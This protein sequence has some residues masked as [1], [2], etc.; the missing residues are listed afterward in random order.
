[1]A[2]RVPYRIQMFLWLLLHNKLLM[3]AERY[4]RHMVDSPKCVICSADEEDLNHV[5]R[6]CPNATLTWQALQS[7]N[8]FGTDSNESREVWL[9]KNLTQQLGVPN[10]PTKFLIT[11]WYIWKWRCKTCFG[12]QEEIPRE[13]N[14]F[15]TA[16]FR[17]IIRVLSLD[18]SRIEHPQA[19]L[20]GGHIKWELPPEGWVILKKDGAA[21]GN[22]GRAGAGGVIRGDRGNWIVGF[23]EHLGHCSSMKA[24][25]R[26][27]FRG[28]QLAK[29]ENLHK[30]WIRTDSL[31]VVG[32]LTNKM[33]WHP[34]HHFLLQQCV[35]LMQQA[36]WEVTITHCYREANQVADFL[37]NKGVDG[38]LGVIKYQSPLVELREA[39]YA[40]AVGVFWPRH[41]KF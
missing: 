19:K 33:Q 18:R 12:S 37:A 25:I 28:L 13:R 31:V 41:D 20:L 22:P 15:L 26:A 6:D 38:T 30:V 23:S 27:V 4:R 3:N 1:M 16:Q 9:K 5:F 36:D 2:I 17:E 40:D 29:E 11:L 8:P 10:W 39:L 14:L 7:H 34:E 35:R 32:M 24:E 21:K